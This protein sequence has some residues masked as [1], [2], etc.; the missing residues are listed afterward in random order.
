MR[1]KTSC[2]WFFAGALLLAGCSGQPASKPA[3]LQQVSTETAAAPEKAVI[4]VAAAADLK[5]ALDEVLV[6]FA[7][8]HPE[9]QVETTFGSSGNFFAQLSNQAPFDLF[10]SAEIDFPRKL[11]EQGQGIAESEFTYAV[12][13]LVVWV[14][15]ESPLDVEQL[16]I[17][18][19]TDPSIRK[20]AIANPK[21]APYGRAAEATLKHYELDDK[22]Q[23][24]LVLGENIAQ[25]AQFVESGAA[26]VGIVALS[27]AL[28]PAMQE[29]GK[30]WPVPLD[31][32]PALTQGG[33]ILSWTKHRSA[34]DQLRSFLLDEP[35]RAT[36][37]RYGFLL[38]GE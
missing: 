11:I 38:P 16:G 32:H 28:A 18:I 15:K 37:K 7:K 12:G 20:I 13:H 1:T 27:L 17:Q 3:P 30:Y 36:L 6:E 14:R 26:D 24:K 35:G 22:V 10:L 5:F 21:V 4:N 23:D 29:Q 34:C 8:Q 2:G 19:L 25:T 31:A 9:I 33:V